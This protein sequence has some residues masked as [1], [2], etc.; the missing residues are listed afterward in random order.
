M[1]KKPGLRK[2][3][4]RKGETKRVTKLRFSFEGQTKKGGVQGGAGSPIPKPQSQE[5]KGI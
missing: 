1:Q 2:K 5:G 4:R 3:S